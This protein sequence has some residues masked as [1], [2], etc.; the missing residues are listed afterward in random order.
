MEPKHPSIVHLLQYFQYDHL[1]EHLQAVSKPFCNLALNVAETLTGPEAS[2]SLRKLL[3]S[4]DCAVRA[5]VS[6]E[7]VE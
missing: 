5:A 4:K 1:P 2:A 3:E 6:G 7:T